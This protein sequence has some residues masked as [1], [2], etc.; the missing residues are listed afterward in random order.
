MTPAERRKLER[1]A[2]RKKEAAAAYNA[3]RAK[4]KSRIDARV[5]R[6]RLKA[7]QESGDEV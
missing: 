1:L 6:A 2:E 3:F 5:R 7:E 4:V